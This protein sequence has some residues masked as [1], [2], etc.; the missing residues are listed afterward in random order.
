MIPGKAFYVSP[1]QVKN[2]RFTLDSFE[3]YH[4]TNVLRLKTGDNIL[5]LDGIGC[6]YLAKVKDTKKT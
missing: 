5:L 4:L 1:N 6:G 3:S 2:N